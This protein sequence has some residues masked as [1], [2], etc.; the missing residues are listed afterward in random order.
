MTVSKRRYCPG[1]SVDELASTV[2]LSKLSSKYLLTY[3]TYVT[4]LRSC[5]RVV[6]AQVITENRQVVV[7]VERGTETS[8]E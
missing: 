7:V 6:V 5:P 3:F 1:S 8:A 4:M 2:V